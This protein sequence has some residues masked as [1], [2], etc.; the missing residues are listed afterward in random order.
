[1]REEVSES[2]F[3]DAVGQFDEMRV[4]TIKREIALTLTSISNCLEAAHDRRGIEFGFDEH[5]EFSAALHLIAQHLAIKQI[6]HPEP[7]RLTGHLINMFV[8]E[9]TLKF[10]VPQPKGLLELFA[11]RFLREAEN[12]HKPPKDLPP[13]DQE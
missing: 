10:Q 7:D 5:F 1:M 8:E 11:C 3:I 12:Q 6:L 9:A 4:R 13:P 2:T